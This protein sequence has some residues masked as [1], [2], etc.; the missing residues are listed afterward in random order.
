MQVRKLYILITATLLG[1]LVAV[2]SR[3]FE[4]VDLLLR[5]RQSNVFQE[6]NILKDKNKD[7]RDEV[8]DLELSIKQLS[9][10]NLALNT[11]EEEINEYKKLSGNVSVFGPG[12]SVLIDGPITTAWAVD[13]VN[14]FFN[15]GAQAVSVNGIR[16]TNQTS[17]FDTLP[18]G[19]ILLNGSILSSPY[20]FNVIGESS[21]L[22]SILELPG[23]IFDRLNA[24]FK[25]T[26][27]E[28][29]SK[30]IVQMG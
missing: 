5:D 28:I 14:E 15:S 23:G 20:T 12:I 3:S 22:I 13:L 17:G 21:T 10:Q 1:F 19:Q 8:R 24:A 9:D 7:L 25:N 26:E 30:E 4:N 27:V 18:Q 29:I 16:I 6:F 2:Q 11:I